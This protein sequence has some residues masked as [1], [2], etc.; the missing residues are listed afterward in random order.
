MTL[1]AF[2]KKHPL[3]EQAKILA[4]EMIITVNGNDGISTVSM[5]NDGAIKISCKYKG[6][7]HEIITGAI[8]LYSHFIEEVLPF[9]G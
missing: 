6:K 4:G 2:N 9:S 5:P 7:T 8:Q 1:G 3:S